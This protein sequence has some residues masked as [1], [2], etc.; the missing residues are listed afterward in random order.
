MTAAPFIHPAFTRQMPKP[1]V[2]PW[3]KGRDV[4]ALAGYIRAALLQ[5]RA[6]VRASAAVALALIAPI[7]GG[8][9][10]AAICQRVT[11]A[12][13]AYASTMEDALTR[14]AKGRDQAA[15]DLGTGMFLGFAGNPVKDVMVTCI[16]RGHVTL[17][18]AEEARGVKIH[19]RLAKIHGPAQTQRMN[20]LLGLSEETE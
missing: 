12:E 7:A 10:M 9:D 5:R 4:R 1:Q 19:D 17:T 3:D 15:C 14:C 2:L 11:A 6:G 8:A 20:E 13:M 16:E 18:K